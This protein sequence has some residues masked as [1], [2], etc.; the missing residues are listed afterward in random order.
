MIV[1]DF[2]SANSEHR[3]ASSGV[4]ILATDISRAAIRRAV[5]G[6]Y[7]PWEVARGLS[8]EEQNKYLEKN[9]I[10]WRVKEPIRRLVQFRRLNLIEPFIGIGTFD[11]IFCRNVLIYFDLPARQR[12]CREFHQLLTSPGWLV[13]GAAENLYGVSDRFESVRRGETLLFK[14]A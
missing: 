5:S 8:P 2:L 14:K 13:L 12:I 10:Q 4:L 3:S 6:I 7:T 9:D 11:I 1:H